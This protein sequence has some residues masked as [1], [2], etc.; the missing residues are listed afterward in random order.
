MGGC[1]RCY[2]A[3]ANRLG[4]R[5]SQAIFP[6]HVGAVGGGVMKWATAVVGLLPGFLLVTG[7]LFWR[8]RRGH[9]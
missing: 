5:M 7:F 3:T 2:D 4:M 9:R 6:L 1:C 8:R